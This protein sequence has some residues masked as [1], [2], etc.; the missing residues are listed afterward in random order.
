MV[1]CL[2]ACVVLV[3]LALLEATSW[4][5]GVLSPLRD[6]LNGMD[7]HV[8]LCRQRASTALDLLYGVLDCMVTSPTAGKSFQRDHSNI[9][10]IVMRMHGLGSGQLLGISPS[11]HVQ[12]LMHL[13]K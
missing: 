11:L 1:Q 8:Y 9:L 13:T 10:C 12:F 6:V 7:S 5:S 3:V 2:G 4:I